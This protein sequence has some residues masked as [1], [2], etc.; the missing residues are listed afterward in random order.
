M[1][2][3]IATIRRYPV[4]GFAGEELPSIAVEAHR[5]IARDRIYAITYAGSPF[6]DAPGWMKKRAFL[7]TMVDET[8]ALS[9]IRFGEG[10]KME[11]AVNGDEPIAIDLSEQAGR[12]AFEAFAARLVPEKQGIEF[13]AMP[14]T[15]F[16]DSPHPYISIINPASVAAIAPGLDERRFRGNLMLADAPAWAEVGWL[17]RE[18]EIGTARGRIMKKIDRCAATTVNPDTAARDVNV[19]KL[20]MQQFGHIDCGV[21]LEITEPGEI[22]AGDSVVVL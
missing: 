9:R 2:A 15:V 4:K 8:L 22:R 17:D 19:P 20:L 7:Q 5:P 13:V 21:Y 16:T 10:D 6:H 14:G 1:N 3:R 12:D 11:I 18:V